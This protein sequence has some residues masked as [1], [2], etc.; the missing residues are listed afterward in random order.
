MSKSVPYK[1]STTNDKFTSRSGLILVAEVMRRRN[2]DNLA[3]RHFP[4]AGSNRGFSAAKY[5]QAFVLMLL[6]GGRCLED[7]RHLKAESDLLSMLGMKRLPG[8]DAPGNW[9]RRMG[10]SKAGLRGRIRGMGESVWQPVVD[11]AGW[12]SEEESSC[13]LGHSMEASKRSFT[14][15]VQRM[16]KWGQ[17]NLE[18]MSDAGTDTYEQD[19]YVYRAIATNRDALSD[20]EVIHWYNQRGEH[21]ENRIKEL[22][23]DFAG[24]R[25]PC[26]AFSS[27]RPRFM[28]IARRVPTPVSASGD[29]EGADASAFSRRK[30]CKGS[31]PY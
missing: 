20:S 16:P 6:E 25:L 7:I 19:G 27:G 21:S 14:L 17:Q 2:V 18:E 13:R 4:V 12:P 10:R 15:V 23:C 9:L 29:T 31:A 22:K 5:I 28:A 8:A 1:L 24:D 11:R 30:K 26:S 3:N